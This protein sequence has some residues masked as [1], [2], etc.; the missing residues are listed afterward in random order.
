MCENHQYEHSCDQY[1]RTLQWVLI[2]SITSRILSTT[3]TIEHLIEHY[4]Q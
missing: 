3:R 4:Q 2:A 1:L